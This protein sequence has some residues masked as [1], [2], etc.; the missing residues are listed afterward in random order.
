MASQAGPTMNLVLFVFVQCLALI[1][2][3]KVD[4]KRK[5]TAQKRNQEA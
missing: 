1:N 5:K 4:G 2:L 3:E